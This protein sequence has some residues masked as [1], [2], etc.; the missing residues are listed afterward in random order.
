MST[1]HDPPARRPTQAAAQTA[2]RG[3][4]DRVSF[5]ELS[6][7]WREFEPPAARR[8]LTAATHAFAERGFHATTTREIAERAGM[9]PAGLYV[10]FSSKEELLYR[11]SLIGHEQALAVL[12]AAAS[13]ARTDDPADRLRVLVS[14]FASWH[15]LHHTATRVIQY[16]MAGLAP[17]H[18]T[19]IRAL[20][21]RIDL[22]IREAIEAGEAAGV[23]E[24][25]DIPGTALAILSLSIDIARW[26]TESN[27][28][29][30]AE[31]GQFYADLAIRMLDGTVG[32][33][34]VDLLPRGRA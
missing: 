19:Q 4:A 21:R 8:L 17:A 13:S 24:V 27:K 22:V 2:G 28:R 25:S 16:E 23:F 33:D 31:I 34:A 29:K 3:Y 14:D 18:L 6:A 11:I 1:K 5:D 12:Q 32:A 9:S 20:R 10:H 15:A 7:A 26:Y 30:P